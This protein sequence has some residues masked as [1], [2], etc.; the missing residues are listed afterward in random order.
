MFSDFCTGLAEFAAAIGMTEDF[1]DIINAEKQIVAG[2][3][4]T[5]SVSVIIKKGFADEFQENI[6]LPL[7]HF[8]EHHTKHIL[9]LRSDKRVRTFV[10]VVG[11]V[12]P[13]DEQVPVHGFIV[14]HQISGGTAEQEP[15][16]HKKFTELPFRNLQFLRRGTDVGTVGGTDKSIEKFRF[17]AHGFHVGGEHFRLCGCAM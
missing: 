7:L 17:R 11:V 8:A 12:V 5:E 3:D 15:G 4:G 1:A 9:A 10:S 16:I 13:D 2:I 14:R 6:Y